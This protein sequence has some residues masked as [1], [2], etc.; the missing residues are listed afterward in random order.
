MALPLP[1][2]P[3][4]GKKAITIVVLLEHHWRLGA[5]DVAHDRAAHHQGNHEQSSDNYRASSFLSGHF[6]IFGNPPD[7]PYFSQRPSYAPTGNQGRRRK[8]GINLGENG[9]VILR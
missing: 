8:A 4:V 1:S 2:L 6:D 3:P 7:Q 5:D 9:S